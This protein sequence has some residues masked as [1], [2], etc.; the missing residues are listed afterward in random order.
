[1]PIPRLVPSNVSAVPEVM[2]VP[3]KKL[4]PFVVWEVALVPPLAT[5][6][7]PESVSVPDEVIGP[8]VKDRPVVPPEASTDVTVPEPPPPPTHEPLI[9]KHPVVKLTPFANVEEAVVEV[10]FKRL[11]ENPPEKV[12]VAVVVAVK[13]AATTSPETP[14]LVYG[15]V[16]PMPTLPEGSMT[17]L[18]VEARA[19]FMLSMENLPL[20]FPSVM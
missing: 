2:E 11:V 10:T 1:V 5:A 16:V 8:P 6:S 17:N 7:V 9:E 14:S 3:L 20:E 13:E 12:E 15:E 19:S 4:T 18:V